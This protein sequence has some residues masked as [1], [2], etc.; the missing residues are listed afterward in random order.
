[1]GEA[2]RKR[3]AMAL[4]AEAPRGT[5]LPLTHYDWFRKVNPIAHQFLTDDLDH[6][7]RNPALRVED[8]LRPK[9]SRGETKYRSVMSQNAGFYM[10]NMQP[11]DRIQ[12][13][14]ELAREY[15]CI[16]GYERYARTT[17]YMTEGLCDALAYTELNRPCDELRLPV[18]CFAMVFDNDV[19]RSALS[20][21][22]KKP[23]PANATITVYIRDDNLDEIGFR[24]LLISVYVMTGSKAVD[25]IIVRKLALRGD[26]SLE[27]A[28]RTD[29][30]TA[31]VAQPDGF[32]TEGF[33]LAA[34]A[35]GTY[36]GSGL[37]I[38]DFFEEGMLFFRMLV[39]GVMYIVSRD[40][41]LVPREDGTYVSAPKLSARPGQGVARS[42][43]EAGPSVPGLPVVID[44][45]QKPRGDQGTAVHTK[46]HLKIRFLVPGFYRRPPNSAPDAKKTIWVHPHHRGPEMATLVHRPYL[47]V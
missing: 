4:R 1:M 13:V 46:R 21:F 34:N 40:A 38:S 30:N 26:W 19:A 2:R 35:D 29:W 8:I 41:E 42:Y 37:S 11:A 45:G 3:E 43:F 27:Q 23:V 33:S 5:T 7:Y 39:N 14:N 10:F 31:G 44:P 20:A 25:N 17:Y 24:R 6:L 18:E 32:T 47:V 36:E 9:A 12:F 15:A 28:L 22:L 16:L